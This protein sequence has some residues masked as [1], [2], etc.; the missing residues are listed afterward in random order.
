MIIVLDAGHTEG[1][2]SRIN[3]YYSEG[4]QMFNFCKI[5]GDIL[6]KLGHKVI[7]TRDSMSSN[8]TLS[9]RCAKGSGAD[10]FLSLH[11]DWA[12][13]SNQVLIFDQTDPKLA[14]PKLAMS[15]GD[16][17]SKYWNCSYRTVYR[18]YNDNWLPEPKAG[19]V[20]Y[21]GVLRGNKARKSMLLELFN[22]RNADA[23]SRFLTVSV[24]T[25]IAKLLASVIQAHYKLN[26]SKGP[27]QS[28][29]DTAKTL[30]RVVSGSYQSREKAKERVDEL[31]KLGQS[32]WILEVRN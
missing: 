15:F 9:D 22:H 23:T 32:S 17:L 3:P 12:G 10:L 6:V 24:Q 16:A 13:A 18:T 29:N 31:R 27:V 7:Y 26:H 21:F 8:P 11:S 28:K 14:D 20:P 25:D 1:D 4:T 19:S 5:L 2:N 30:Y